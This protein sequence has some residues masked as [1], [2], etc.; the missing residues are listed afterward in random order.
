MRQAFICSLIFVWTFAIYRFIYP[1]PR[2]WYDHYMY[3]ARSF[4]HGRVDIPNLPEYFQDKILVDD[5]IYV[6]FPPMPAIFLT[7]ITKAFP[8]ITQQEVSIVVGA[9]NAVLVFLL[10]SKFTNRSTALL[11]S[12]FFSFGTVA[13]WSAI[14]GTTWYFA[15]NVAFMFLA[16]SIISFKNKWDL[17]AG[18]FFSLAVLSRYPTF[19]GIIF[20]TLELY[21]DRKRLVKF[22]IGALLCIPFQLVYDYLRFGNILETGY[23][24]VYKDYVNSSYPY[25]IMQLIAPGTPYFGYLDPRNVPLHLFTFLILPPIVTQSL[26]IS[27]SPYG[28]GILFTSPLLFLTLRPNL[29]NTLE[30]N[31]FLGASA[32]ALIDFMHYMQGWVQFGYRFVMDFMPFLIILLALKFK[33]KRSHIILFFISLIVSTWGTLQGIKLGW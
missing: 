23:V 14:V 32:I 3:Q 5:K 27:P 9:L 25:T 7:P 29:I 31:L 28:L 16:A 30:R 21:K 2:T 1:E 22:L 19:M 33:P 12:M 20:F 17:L 4:L 15:H 10:V 8:D 18:I 26:Q 13:F 6:P 24:K 11:V